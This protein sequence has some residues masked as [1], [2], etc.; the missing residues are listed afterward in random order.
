MTESSKK[1]D[2]PVPANGAKK[3]YRSTTIQALVASIVV[4][5]VLPRLGIEVPAEY[6]TEIYAALASAVIIGLRKASGG[7]A[8]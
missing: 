7:L 8:L 4:L 2:K 3:W 1:T 5:V 6:S